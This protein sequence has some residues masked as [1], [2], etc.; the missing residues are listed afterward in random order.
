MTRP[1]MTQPLFVFVHG[2]GFGPAVWDGVRNALS[3]GESVAMDLGF[4]GPPSLPDLPAGHPV[5][6]VGHSF[7]GLWL[8]HERPFPW[9]GLVLVNGFPRFTEGNGFAPATPRRVLDRMIARFDTAP[10]AVT[11]D[12]LR[13]CDCEAPPPDGLDPERLGEALRA[14]RDWD[15]RDSLTGPA[16]ALA[17]GQDPIVPPTMTE[18]AFRN[19]SVPRP[20]GER[21]APKAPGGGVLGEP[22]DQA[23]RNPLTLTLSPRGRGDGGCGQIS[24]EWHPE[25]GHLLPLTA[26][27][28]CAERIAAFATGLT[29]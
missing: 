14:L 16:L 24:V 7:G 2:W 1:A 4:Y 17:G 28:W 22:D 29:A 13:R 19:H 26:P 6:A 11:A 15:A 20:S 21:G 9:D 25:G 18:Q 3:E 10:E 27:G 23:L 12:F 5:V 8:L